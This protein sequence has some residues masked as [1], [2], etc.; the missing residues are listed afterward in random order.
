MLLR[1][2]NWVAWKAKSCRPTYERFAADAGESKA[3]GGGAGGNKSTQLGGLVGAARRRAANAMK[4]R[5][6]C[7]LAPPPPVSPPALTKASSVISKYVHGISHDFGRLAVLVNHQ[8]DTCHTFLRF[9]SILFTARTPFVA[10]SL[11]PSFFHE[12]ASDSFDLKLM[13]AS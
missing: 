4:V 11:I 12:Y 2:Q 1:E 13:I 10:C 3:S 7:T 5:F 6:G 9:S 8:L